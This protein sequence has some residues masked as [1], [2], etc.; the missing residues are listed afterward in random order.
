MRE[1]VKAGQKPVFVKKYSNRRNKL[2]A[3]SIKLDYFE[4]GERESETKEV[5]QMKRYL[6]RQQRITETSASSKM[7]TQPDRS[8]SCMN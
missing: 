1:T 7:K 8:K 6:S 4:E 2:I 3:S 5:G